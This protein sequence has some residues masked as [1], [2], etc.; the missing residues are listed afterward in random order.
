MAKKNSEHIKERRG[1]GQDSSFD[2]D[3]IE[4]EIIT[5]CDKK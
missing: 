3:S 1:G 4:K 2:T 5:L